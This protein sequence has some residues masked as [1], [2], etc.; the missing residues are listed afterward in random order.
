MLVSKTRYE[1]S[2]PSTPGEERLGNITRIIKVNIKLG[3]VFEK[4][5]QYLREVMQEA[6][7][8]SWPD[9]RYVTMAT[10]IILIIVAIVSVFIWGVDLFFVR[11]WDFL[12]ATF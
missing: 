12:S 2:I 11:A 10:T 3:E 6:K 9:Q 1:G 8:V 5:K 7:K 4:I